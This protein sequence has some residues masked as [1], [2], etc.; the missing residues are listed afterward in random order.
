MTVSQGATTG[1]QPRRWPC[2]KP[3]RNAVNTALR[4]SVQRRVRPAGPR[5]FRSRTWPRGSADRAAAGRETLVPV[6]LT[7]A[8]KRLEVAQPVG[9]SVAGI[10]DVKLEILA[11]VAKAAEHLGGRGRL[12]GDARGPPGDLP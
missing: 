1:Q 10:R 2:R 9:G 5:S 12:P 4:R 8:E 6:V 7:L 11:K 3:C